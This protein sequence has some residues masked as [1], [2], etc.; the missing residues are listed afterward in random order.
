MREGLGEPLRLTLFEL[1]P[2][3]RQCLSTEV[4]RP[5]EILQVINYCCSMSAK[6][7]ESRVKRLEDLRVSNAVPNRSSRHLK[8]LQLLSPSQNR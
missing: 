3:K 2:D 4:G 6:Q 5:A 1:T 7:I 8:E